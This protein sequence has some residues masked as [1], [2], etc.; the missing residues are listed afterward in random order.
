MTTLS[1][2]EKDFL[3]NMAK[4][5]FA[6]KGALAINS[7]SSP[8]GLET[9]TKE[10]SAALAAFSTKM[11]ASDKALEALTVQ[12]YYDVRTEETALRNEELKRDALREVF[13]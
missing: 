5:L 11:M 13:F 2:E 1:A 9:A 8:E 4:W 12:V 7:L 3:D 6:S 10:Y